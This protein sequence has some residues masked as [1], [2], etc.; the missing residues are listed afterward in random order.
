VT[1]AVLASRKGYL[2]VLGAFIQAASARGHRVVLLHDPDEK[3]P[4]EAVTATDLAQWPQAISRPHRRGE[5]LLPALRAAGAEALVGPSLHLLLRAMGVEGEAPALRAA[6]IRLYS[7]DYVFDTVASA[8]EGY[9]VVDVT[10]YMSEHQRQVHWRVQREAF[11]AIGSEAE[12]RR[13]SAVV[14]STMLD[15]LALVDRA[16][17]RRKYGLA[18]DRPVV[19]LMSLKMAVPEPLRRL[20]WAGGWRGWRAAKALATGHRALVPAILRGNGYLALAEALRGFSRRAGA[21]FVVKSRAKNAD[22]RFLTR[23][24]DLFIE[25]DEDVFPYTSIELVAI[26]DLCVHFQSGAVLEAALAGV[27]SLSIRV[28]QTHLEGYASFQEVFGAKPGSMQNFP[29]LVWSMD[30]AEATR[31]LAT[32][33]L[34]DFRVDGG[35]R[36]R[37]IES[38]LGFDD[39]QSSGRL[40]D[41]I[42]SAGR[43]SAAGRPAAAPPA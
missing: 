24:A 18:P 14:G 39:T 37:Y 43:V 22:P 1:L 6:G 13:R 26:S 27:P 5:A 35:A 11:A 42:E 29:G 30:A 3:K 19:L 25:R 15:Q 10:C 16:A 21:S 20:T 33:G 38:F 23:R 40:L 32:A 31:R 4:G 2:K 8:P 12:L 41:V 7:V 17:V 9:R 34:A 28:P 36:R